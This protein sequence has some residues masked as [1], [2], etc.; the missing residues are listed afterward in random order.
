MLLENEDIGKNCSLHVVEVDLAEICLVKARA[1]RENSIVQ[2]ADC[3]GNA[4]VH[5]NKDCIFHANVVNTKS[6][7]KFSLI[8]ADLRHVDT[9]QSALSFLSKDQPVLVLCELV[10]I[11]LGQESCDN[12]LTWCASSLF[13][14]PF[15]SLV[16]WEPLGPQETDDTLQ[17]PFQSVREGYKISYYQQFVDKLDS[18]LSTRHSPS[19]EEATSGA[20]LSP[21][22]SSTALVE[23]RLKQ[24]GFGRVHALLA[25][26][27]A[28]RA[29]TKNKGAVD[30]ECKELFDEQAALALHLQ[31]YALVCAFS[32]R[33]DPLFSQ[34]VC[35]WIIDTDPV[36]AH[37]AN[38][39][40]IWLTEMAQPYETGLRDL[41]CQT[42]EPYF[43]S[44]PAIHKMVK[45][46][47]KRDLALS[48]TMAV[49]RKDEPLLSPT[50]ASA[51]AS[52]Y[53]TQ[54]GFFIVALAAG[55]VSACRDTVT[56]SH[57]SVDST[58]VSV[59]GGIGIRRMTAK[60]LVTRGLNDDVRYFEIHRL[61]VANALSG[62]GVGKKLL[63][64]AEQLLGKKMLLSSPNGTSDN[65]IKQP[66]FSL[67]ATTPHVLAA[68]N[69]F[70][71]SAGFSVRDEVVANGLTMRTFC[72]RCE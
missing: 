71:Q 43:S 28:A 10:L 20:S 51:I 9:L 15:S 50:S 12:L 33:A 14:H 62:M 63:R 29:V 5:R 48:S 39:Q 11:Y 7:A 41:F 34:L 17:R 58:L 38:G 37:L 27:A 35:P 3:D 36:H 72:K 60:E 53:Q 25:G 69:Q 22:G 64:R 67:I 23:S 65:P 13:Q 30:L 16:A 47:L 68:A 59:I 4:A 1:L 2:L 26:M 52:Y 70:Y 42:Y 40:G 8:Q 54:G 45:T 49:A 21:L 61:L 46:A 32:P 44:Y 57:Q 19:E 6:R 55:G 66:S 56:G 24:L 18:G 31:S